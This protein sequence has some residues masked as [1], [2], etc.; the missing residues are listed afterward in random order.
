MFLQKPNID[1]QEGDDTHG[2]LGMGRFLLGDDRLEMHLHWAPTA[3]LEEPR[4]KFKEHIEEDG[5][6]RGLDDEFALIPLGLPPLRRQGGEVQ[7]GGEN[8]SFQLQQSYTSLRFF[9]ERL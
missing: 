1:P 7:T 9:E 6:A 4:K 2:V 8:L 5:E 3:L